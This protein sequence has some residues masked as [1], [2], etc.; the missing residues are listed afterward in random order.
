ME[1]DQC[2]LCR[3]PVIDCVCPSEFKSACC[4]KHL[5]LCECPDEPVRE[6]YMFD[7]NRWGEETMRCLRLWGFIK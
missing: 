6:S 3:E 2:S 5:S 7:L 4:E 1:I